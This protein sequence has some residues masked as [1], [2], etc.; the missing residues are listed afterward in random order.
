MLLPNNSACVSISAGSHRLI[1]GV[2]GLLEQ[3]LLVVGSA[4]GRRSMKGTGES[5]STKT[6]THSTGKACKRNE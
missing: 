6:R 4:G 2:L 5:Y 1:P 3:P